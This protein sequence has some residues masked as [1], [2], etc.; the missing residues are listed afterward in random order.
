[1]RTDPEKVGA[2]LQII[3]THIG[4]LRDRHDKNSRIFD[5]LTVALEG[6][7]FAWYVVH[8]DSND[9]DAALERVEFAIAWYRRSRKRGR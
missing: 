1:M 9:A 2:Q 4:K 3:L 6:L 7:R 5:A 8:R